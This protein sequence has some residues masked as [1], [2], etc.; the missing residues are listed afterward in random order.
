MSGL[1]CKTAESLRLLAFAVA[2]LS[3][4][5]APAFADVVP[6]EASLTGGSEAP[7]NDSPATGQLEG[8]LD[9]DT[10]TLE[11]TVTYSGLTGP[12][13][14]ADFHGP[15][16]LGE[17]APIEVGTPGALA[18]PFHGVARIDA[19]Q[20]NDLKAGRWYFNLHSKTFPA[21]EIRGPV[22]RR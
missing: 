22:V 7:P 18:S 4:A 2:A 15:A 12:A 17:N 13:L 19:T 20:V 16:P 9:T 6:I 5:D 21:G 1:G 11:W 14:S 10:N 8:T 3:A